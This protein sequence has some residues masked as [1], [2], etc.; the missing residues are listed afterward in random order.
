MKHGT[1]DR[2]KCHQILYRQD[3]DDSHLDRDSLCPQDP[4]KQKRKD[5]LKIGFWLFCQVKRNQC[6]QPK[7]PRTVLP[8]APATHS[9]NTGCFP[10]TWL[11]AAPLTYSSLWATVISYLSSN[12]ECPL[13]TRSFHTGHQYAII[14]PISHKQANTRATFLNLIISLYPPT[15]IFF[16]S[17]QKNTLKCVRGGSS[18][19]LHG[20]CKVCLE[21]M[22]QSPVRMLI[23]QAN[24]YTFIPSLQKH[25]ELLLLYPFY[26]CIN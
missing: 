26:Q 5:P 14:Y 24:V 21:L 2:R 13:F 19:L 20:T 8:H 1:L 17:L 12:I 15:S 11:R 7:R 18:L 6:W 16:S 10:G 25:A 3:R 22:A 9:S 23:R 4:R